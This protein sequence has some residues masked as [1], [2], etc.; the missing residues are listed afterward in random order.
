[1]RDYYENRR[2]EKFHCEK[3]QYVSKE[4]EDVKNHYMEKHTKSYSCW[5]CDLEIGTISVFKEHYGSYH[6]TKEDEVEI[7]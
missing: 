3:C 7:E 2:K 5:E 1:M 4:M 6:F